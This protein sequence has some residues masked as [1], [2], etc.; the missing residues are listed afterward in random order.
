LNKIVVDLLNGTKL[1]CTKLLKPRDQKP[2]LEVDYHGQTANDLIKEMLVSSSPCMI[3]RLGSTE[4]KA[5]LNYFDIICNGSYFSKS[6]KY[7]RGETGPFWWEDEI[8][9]EMLNCSGF[10][11]PRA[12]YLERFAKM[13]LREMQNI[14]V[15]GSWIAGEYRLTNYFPNAS[16]IRLE[17][18]EPYYHS[19][20]WSEVLEGKRVL[21]I[22]PFAESIKKQY[23]KHNVLFKDPRVLPKFE[24]KILKAV[25][26]LDANNT[27]F[28]N[29]FDALSYMKKRVSSIDFDIAIIGAGAYGLQLASFVRSI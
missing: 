4:L 9:V 8:K 15:L 29:W 10:F 22:H 25:Q 20:P 1:L 3:C 13:M 12:E 27:D 2:C 28:S 7:I 18:L 16:I 19:N 17:D 11:P 21:V 14:D 5:T 26:S 6:I 23:K 24:L